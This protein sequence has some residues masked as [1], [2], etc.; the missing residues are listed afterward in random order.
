MHLER[1][2]SFQIG[3]GNH[4][5]NGKSIIWVPGEPGWPTGP[6]WL[7]GLAWPAGWL[8][9]W[10]GWHPA[11][12]ERAPASTMPP[13]PPAPITAGGLRGIAWPAGKMS[14]KSDR[15]NGNP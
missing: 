14:P 15:F 4:K 11:W 9:G 12:P 5:M 13:P 7:A 1:K 2:F 6:A 3:F 10:P 8:P